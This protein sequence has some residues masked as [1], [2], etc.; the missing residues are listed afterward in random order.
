MISLP[1]PAVPFLPEKWGTKKKPA[2][3]MEP[4][5]QVF[6][7]HTFFCSYAV[8][9]SYPIRHFRIAGSRSVM[10]LSLIHNAYSLP[11]TA[12]DTVGCK[13]MYSRADT[14]H[15]NHGGY[16]LL[17]CLGEIVILQL[18]KLLL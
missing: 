3:N 2:G 4:F 6:I 1:Y 8:S 12:D 14:Q 11:L 13:K 16:Q 15:G 18:Y 17:L 9:K 7:L 10:Q 5:P